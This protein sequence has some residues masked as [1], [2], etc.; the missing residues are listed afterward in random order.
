MVLIFF[1][2]VSFAN[3]QQLEMVVTRCFLVPR[4][5]RTICGLQTIFPS[6]RLEEEILEVSVQLISEYYTIIM[7]VFQKELEFNIFRWTSP[8]VCQNEI[9]LRLKQIGRQVSNAFGISAGFS[10]I[11][12]VAN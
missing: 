11:P 2:L 6:F 8:Y 9:D 3:F 12:V 1:C 7:A 10:Q 4:Q 5:P